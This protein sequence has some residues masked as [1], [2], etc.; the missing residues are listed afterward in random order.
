MI[1]QLQF[2]RKSIPHTREVDWEA[3]Y[4]EDRPRLYNFFCYRYDLAAFYTRL[5]EIASEEEI[6][7]SS[8]RYGFRLNSPAQV[9]PTGAFNSS[10][11]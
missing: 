1:D 6:F 3:A 10:N 11:L 4:R 2:F 9:K 5:F 7:G 8:K